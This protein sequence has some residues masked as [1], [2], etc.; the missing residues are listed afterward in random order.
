M[1]YRSKDKKNF[2]FIDKKNCA[3][4]SLKEVNCF[5]SHVTCN[6]GKVCAIKKIIK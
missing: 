4:K 5:L 6:V 2:S 1:D 3:L